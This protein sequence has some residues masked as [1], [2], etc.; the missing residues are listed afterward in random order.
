MMTLIHTG[1]EEFSCCF[2]RL[3]RIY[4]RSGYLFTS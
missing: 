2:A 1:Q 3:V 4:D